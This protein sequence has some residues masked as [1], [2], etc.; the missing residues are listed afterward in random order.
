MATIDITRPHQL[1]TATA[2]ERAEELAKDMQSK[3]GIDWNWQGDNI[4]FK[5]DKGAAK[6]AK[7]QVSVT[8]ENV[9]VAIDL[10]LMLRA[11]K[12]MVEK[13]VASKLDTLIG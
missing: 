9:R 13:Q 10:P 11:M 3:L 5:A 4:H 1:G 8:E 6:G 7:G 2:K 12:G